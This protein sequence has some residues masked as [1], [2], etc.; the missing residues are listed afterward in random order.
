MNQAR[1]DVSGPSIL[2]N[3]GRPRK[4]RARAGFTASRAIAS[5]QFFVKAKP[6]E[7][8]AVLYSYGWLAQCRSRQ[9]LLPRRGV[10][11]PQTAKPA[12]RALYGAGIRSLSDLAQVSR[13]ELT[14]LHGI[15]PNA[16]ATLT[17]AMAAQRIR[18]RAR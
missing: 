1:R 16:L 5:V 13:A 12:L 6:A 11:P 15:G 4:S 14:A 7:F 10:S 8:D 17:R 9:S 2:S 18:F 3:E